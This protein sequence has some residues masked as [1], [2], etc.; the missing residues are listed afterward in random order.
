MATIN[1]TH[2]TENSHSRKPRGIL[3]LI[4]LRARQAT[5]AYHSSAMP[6]WSDV[7]DEIPELAALARGFL[8]AHVQRH[9]RRSGVTAPRVSAAAK[10]FSPTGSCGW[11]A[12][13]RR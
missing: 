7:E 6:S 2:E 1:E 12:C 4:P 10:S 11:G 9:S 13:G 8:D 5:P 3:V